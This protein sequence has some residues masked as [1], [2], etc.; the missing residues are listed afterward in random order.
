MLL[1]L[2]CLR[3]QAVNVFFLLGTLHMQRQRLTEGKDN[4]NIYHF[5]QGDRLRGD[6]SVVW[7]PSLKPMAISQFKFS[8]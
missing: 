7:R 2:V 8:V 5:K 4:G 1:H 3:A 6:S